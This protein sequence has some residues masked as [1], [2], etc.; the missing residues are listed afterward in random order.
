[1]M[2]KEYEMSG[3]DPSAFSIPFRSRPLESFPEAA[4][5]P[6]PPS[7]PYGDELNPD[8]FS[9]TPL[10]TTAS[11]VSF[12]PWFHNKG[13]PPLQTVFFKLP[14]PLIHSPSRSFSELFRSRGEVSP[15]FPLSSLEPA[16]DPSDLKVL[17][18]RDLI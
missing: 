18:S 4:F 17:S 3:S 10:H 14:D 16:S 1:M 13:P 12:V 8:F 9:S 7:L 11:F 6:S 5:P 2:V 15:S